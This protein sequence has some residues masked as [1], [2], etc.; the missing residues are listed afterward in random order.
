MSRHSPRYRSPSM[1]PEEETLGLESRAD[2]HVRI[3]SFCN[4]KMYRWKLQRGYIPFIV[5]LG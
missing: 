4:N 2:I 5:P 3:F 1:T